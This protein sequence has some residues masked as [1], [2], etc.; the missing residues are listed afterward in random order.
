MKIG[1]VRMRV[2]PGSLPQAPLLGLEHLDVEGV[3][4]DRQLVRAAAWLPRRADL[5]GA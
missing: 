1:V 4:V 5:A 3:T 2:S